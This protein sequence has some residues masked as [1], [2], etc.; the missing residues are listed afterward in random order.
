MFYNRL[1]NTCGLNPSEKDREKHCFLILSLLSHNLN[2]KLLFSQKRVSKASN[3]IA[4][5]FWCFQITLLMLYY[6]AKASKV[7]KLKDLLCISINN[8]HVD[9]ARFS[10][11]ISSFFFWIMQFTCLPC[12]NLDKSEVNTADLFSQWLMIR[13]FINLIVI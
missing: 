7:L 8:E 13:H 3:L 9:F 1:G 2:G 6:R 4:C 10:K 11:K 12:K 5:C